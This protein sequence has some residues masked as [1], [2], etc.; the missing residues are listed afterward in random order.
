MTGL[1][2]AFVT[3]ATSYAGA[4]ISLAHLVAA[5][6]DDVRVTVVATDWEVARRVVS[7]RGD[8]DVVLVPPVERQARPTPGE[9]ARHHRALRSVDAD[10]IQ[11]NLR[12]PTACRAAQLA[13]AAL[14]QRRVVA[15]NHLP[16]PVPNLRGR[17]AVRA[18]AR[19]VDVHVAVGT[20]SAREVEA[21]CGLPKG[22][23]RVV[24]NGIP[25]ARP[26]RRRTAPSRRPVVGTVARFDPQKQLDVLVRAVAGLADV[27]LHLVGDGPER[28][29]LHDLVHAFGMEQRTVFHGWVDDTR[30]L[31]DEMDV[32]VLPSRHEAFPLAVL[33][34][35]AAGVPVVA[36][37]VGSVSDVVV[38]GRTGVL[39]PSGDADA[40][41]A[42]VQRLLADRATAAEL[43]ATAYEVVAARY[44]AAEMARSFEGIYAELAP[45]LRRRRRADLS[46]TL[47]PSTASPSISRR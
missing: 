2:V 4:E 11:L 41:G 34:A 35:M 25:L 19:V 8:A 17:L 18:L 22:T 46:E 38:D 30:Q 39:V 16:L 32:F 1:H 24:P 6:R 20:A 15:V 33:E 5:L 40:L 43:A 42:A 10:V 3:D 28:G 12:E 31:L 21:I 36:T 27:S 13:A 47:A 7:A 29:R 37:D 44:T 26:R 45:G 14:R 9:V 23:V